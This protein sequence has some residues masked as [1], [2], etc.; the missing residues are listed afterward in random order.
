MASE[1]GMMG[2]ASSDET[3]GSMPTASHVT[4]L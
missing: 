2:S 3:A 4:M 1:G